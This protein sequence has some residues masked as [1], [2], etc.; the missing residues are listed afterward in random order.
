M[1][2]T[3]KQLLFSDVIGIASQILDSKTSSW[4]VCRV[5]CLLNRGFLNVL[6]DHLGTD[7]RIVFITSYFD[8]YAY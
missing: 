1:L 5:R 6:V 8:G 7:A 4:A 2:R 3:T